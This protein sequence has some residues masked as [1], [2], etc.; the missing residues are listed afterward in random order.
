MTISLRSARLIMAAACVCSALAASPLAHSQAVPTAAHQGKSAQPTPLRLADNYDSFIEIVGQENEHIQAQIQNGKVPVTPR[1]DYATLIGI[2]KDE[3]ETMLAIIL[4][5][6]QRG[7]SMEKQHEQERFTF[8]SQDD[9]SDPSV[10]DK[11]SRMIQES[12]NA[13]HNKRDAMLIETVA[14]LRTQLG[15][16]SFAKLNESLRSGK[17]SG[18]YIDG[19]KQ[20]IEGRSDPCPPNNNP[21]PG[22]TTH[23]ACAKIYRNQIFEEIGTIDDADR[24]VAAAGEST[25]AIRVRFTL[26]DDLSE[27][28][29]EA[30]I[31]LGVEANRAIWEIEK[32]ARAEG[33]ASEKKSATTL[34]EYIFKLKQV[35]GDEFFNNLDTYLSKENKLRN[36]PLVREEVQQ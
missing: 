18:S 7:H 29:R 13:F 9:Q 21:P 12:D 19:I 2:S 3:E 17:F 6:F 27:D 25:G 24:E 36:P 8:I 33:E 30:A 10:R 35:V 5:A 11:V 31:A 14:K 32:K 22:Q 26:F 15:E 23:L 34:E 4:D 16:K 20:D 1:R 28:R